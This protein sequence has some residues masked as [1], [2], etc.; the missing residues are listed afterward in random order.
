MKKVFEEVIKNINIIKCEGSI[1]VSINN[2]DRG[3][4][5]QKAGSRKLNVKRYK[6]ECKEI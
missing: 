4:Y 3:Y 6:V 1:C 2:N 5:A